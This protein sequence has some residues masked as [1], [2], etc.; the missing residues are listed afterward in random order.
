MRITL[1]STSTYPS[2]QGIRTIS[3]VLKSKGH[4]VRLV[5]MTESE[6]YS[7]FYSL[8]AL[9]QLKEL[10]KDSDIIG[11][12][13]MT[14][15]SKRAVQIIQ[16][17][18]SL[19]IP[20]L[21]GGVHAT[22]APEECI[23]HADIV[24]VGEG[25]E[26][27]L[28][29]VNNLEKKKSITGIKNLWIKSNGKIIRNP[30]RPLIQNLDKLPFV[31]YEVNDHY[32]LKRNIVKFS[33][34]DLNG[35]IFF[36][37]GR[38]CPYCC[39]YCSNKAFNN[40]Y[41][42]KWGRVRWHSPDYIIKG[43]LYLKQKYPSLQIF[44]IRD[45][46]FSFRPL[47]QIKEFCE[48]YKKNVKLRMKCLG[49]PRTIDKEKVRLLVD[50][51]CTDF[52]MG[53]QGSERIN[54]EVYK[55]PQRDIDVIKAAKILSEFKELAVMYD[56]ITSNPY[57]GAQ[58]IVDL[59]NLLRRLPIPFYLSVNNLVFFTG[60][61]LYNR[62][63]KEGI[64]KNEK[65]AAI[66]LNYWDRWKHILLKKK[67][68]YLNLILN[69]MRGPV[70]S[71]RF[72]LMPRFLLKFLV[73]PSMIRFNEKNKIP[74]IIIGNIVGVMDAVREKIAKPIYRSLPLNFKVWY[75]KVRYKV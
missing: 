69:L 74:T 58:D 63:L 23:K 61:E 46:T 9:S 20:I 40:V 10:C 27:I 51:G 28:E 41:A 75:D 67:N 45:D 54:L 17:L 4:K 32:I 12:S 42:G 39:T 44:D 70:S 19:N 1:I 73:Q 35:Y 3:S 38:G 29:L 6:D 34:T 55:R 14:S 62:A 68:M 31:D 25:E 7:K 36:L 37:T 33:E 71:S 24:C 15:T 56:V 8:K 5:F 47:N 13:S 53:I 60:S 16:S 26:A 57:E 66:E 59:I 22:L 72:G 50:A 43:I 18:R 65:D 48:K 2:D 11:I 52:I 49:D 64:I 21:W 30:P